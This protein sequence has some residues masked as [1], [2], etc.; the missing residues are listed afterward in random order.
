MLDRILLEG[1]DDQL[2]L[3]IDLAARQRDAAFGVWIKVS[4]S[5]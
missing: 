3:A 5:G 1:R 2:L 4:A